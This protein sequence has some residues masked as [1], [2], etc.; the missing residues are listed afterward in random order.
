MAELSPSEATAGPKRSGVS[1]TVAWRVVAAGAGWRVTDV[2]CGAGPDDRPY[3]ESHD[4]ACIAAVT[5]G[6]F[7]YRSTLGG[8]VFAP[9]ALLL[10][11][12]GTCFECRHEH[13]TGDRCLAFHFTP[14]C[15]ETIM[16]AV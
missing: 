10:G 11:N 13:S 12:S 3:E 2:R 16:T 4:I 5:G 8:A 1:G 14:E 9:G 6:V 7:Q 15:L